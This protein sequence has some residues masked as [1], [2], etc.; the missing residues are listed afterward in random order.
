FETSFGRGFAT[1]TLSQSSKLK[2]LLSKGFSFFVSCP[3]YLKKQPF[4]FGRPGWG[5]QQNS[6]LGFN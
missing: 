2:S 3:N 1:Q 4:F 6:G 5:A